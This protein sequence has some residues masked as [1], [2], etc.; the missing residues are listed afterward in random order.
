MS[1]TVNSGVSDLGGLDVGNTQNYFIELF[2]HLAAR[3]T[4][5]HSK[6]HT[7][8]ALDPLKS[9]VAELLHHIY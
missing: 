3:H 2:W 1:A 7:C 5:T 8:L 4:N 6:N 9:V